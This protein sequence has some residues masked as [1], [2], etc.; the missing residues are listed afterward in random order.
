MSNAARTILP[1]PCAS[2]SG[3]R[4]ALRRDLLAALRVSSSP[5][6]VNVSE[7]CSLNQED[8][9]L[10]L[11]CVAQAAGRDTQLFFVTGSLANRVLLEVTRISSVAP[12]FNSVTEALAYPQMSAESEA[13]DQPASESQNVGGRK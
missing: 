6:I 9:D 2:S 7:C 5:V 1:F 4:G 13:K 12:V 3:R 10:L 11:D 8:L